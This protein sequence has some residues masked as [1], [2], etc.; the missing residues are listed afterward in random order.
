MTAVLWPKGAL[1]V[2]SH[3]TAL[4]LMDLSD[5][6]P[7][8]I[9][10]TV[11]AKHRVRRRE[12]PPAVALHRADLAEEEIGSIEGLPVTRATRTIRDC[13]KASLGPALLSQALADALAKGWLSEIESRKLRDE[14]VRER[15]L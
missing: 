9:H 8:R 14:L 15:F 6:N 11:P 1:G 7:S 3:E 4:S 13:A 10:V 5:A 12:T 2:L